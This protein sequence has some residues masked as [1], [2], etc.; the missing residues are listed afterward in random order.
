M[1]NAFDHT[2]KNIN[3]SKKSD[4][5]SFFIAPQD[6]GKLMNHFRPF[7]SRDTFDF[8]ICGFYSAAKHL[9]K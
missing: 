2:H 3:V 4:S 1:L 5:N 8:S 7:D 9:N 6:S